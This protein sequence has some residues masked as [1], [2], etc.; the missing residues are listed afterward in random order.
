MIQYE[1]PI[2]GAFSWQAPVSKLAR[3]HSQGRAG[4]VATEKLLAFVH[5][6]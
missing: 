1:P 3:G 5:H 4:I 6:C 2:E